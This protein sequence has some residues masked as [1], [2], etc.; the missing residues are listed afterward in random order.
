MQKTRGTS[1][2]KNLTKRTIESLPASPEATTYRDT[3]ARHLYL[4]VSPTGRKTW[5]FVAKVNGRTRFVTIGVY[6]TITPDAARGE[7]NRL[8]V[9][10]AAG[11]DPGAE[12]KKLRNV[13]T[14]GELFQWFM[15]NHSRPKKRSWPL[16]EKLEKRYCHAWRSWPYT[17]LTS[18]VIKRWHTKIGN[19]HGQHQADRVLALVKAVFS[20]ALR[21]EE[22]TGDN[23]AAHVEKYFTDPRK[24]GRNRYLQPD[25]IKR[26]FNALDAHPDQDMSDFFRLCLLTGARRANV[27]AMRWAHMDRTDPDNPTWVIPGD[28]SKNEESIRVPLLPPAL[29]I[30]NRRYARRRSDTWVFP[31][32]HANTKCPHLSEPK[33]AWAAI[34]AKGKLHGVHIHDL[35]RTLGSWQALQGA[36]LQIIGRS[37]GHRSMQ[38]T[39]IYARLNDV[40]VRE[41]MNQAVTKMIEAANGDTKAGAK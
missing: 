7:S 29:I 3:V 24:Y 22:I 10:Y 21:A 16:D 36:S 17:S 18:K 33:K 15:E 13:G 35:R 40:V 8:A 34:C 25:E 41:S 30:L 6:P 39:E 9:E 11:R 14:W 5:R 12:R 26:L 19:D 38:S 4:A 27:Q 2:K 32:K 1:Q 28:E 23:P 20:E 31:S 37:L